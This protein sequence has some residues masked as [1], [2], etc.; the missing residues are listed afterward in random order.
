M[1]LN[2]IPLRQRLSPETYLLL[3]FADFIDLTDGDEC[4]VASEM[5]PC[6]MDDNED[7]SSD[8]IRSCFINSHTYCS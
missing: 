3:S 7:R 1:K 4:M 5:R 2:Y 8:R 6:D